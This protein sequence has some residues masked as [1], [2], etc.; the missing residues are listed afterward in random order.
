MSLG[1]N[2][3]SQPVSAARTIAIVA[4]ANA[5]LLM[6]CSLR[7]ER[8]E[9]GLSGPGSRRPLSTAFHCATGANSHSYRRVASVSIAGVVIWSLFSVTLNRTSP[10]RRALT[11]TVY[12]ASALG[13]REA[14]G[15][16]VT[17]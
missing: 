8:R 5:V 11:V 15:A 7:A 4:V 1:V 13:A 9:T 14:S 17:F 6:P 2:S 3:C 16:N 12:S 10:A